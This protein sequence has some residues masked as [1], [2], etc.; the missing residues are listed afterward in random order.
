MQSN[1]DQG[2]SATL[3]P[4]PT[5][6]TQTQAQEPNVVTGMAQAQDLTQTMILRLRMILSG[7][8]GQEPATPQVAGQ[9]GSPAN[10][11]DCV[12][13]HG[14]TLNECLSVVDGI[15]RALGLPR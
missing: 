9:S 1:V 6:A 14:L 7:L 5:A 11:V 8:K 12:Q 2:I 13:V 10:L 3:P 15:E 4:F